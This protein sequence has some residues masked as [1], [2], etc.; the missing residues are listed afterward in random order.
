[1]RLS[2]DQIYR[3]MAI[4][5]SA[6]E[7]KKFYTALLLGIRQAFDRVRIPGLLHKVS[8]YLP[9]EYVQYCSNTL[10]IRNSQFDIVN[11]HLLLNQ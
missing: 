6:L 8:A 2:I 9:T 5:R 7:I 3:V 11:H 10:K 1:M 4:I